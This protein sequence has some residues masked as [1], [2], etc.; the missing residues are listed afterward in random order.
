MHAVC[1]SQHLHMFPY[2][3]VITIVRQVFSALNILVPL[4]FP[5]VRKPGDTLQCN[6]IINILH[7][8]S[9]YHSF[10]EE[11]ALHLLLWIP[12]NNTLK[13]TVS[14][15]LS[16]QSSPRGCTSVFGISTI[17]STIMMLLCTFP[18]RTCH[19]EPET[20][21]LSRGLF[22]VVRKARFGLV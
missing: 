6:G 9:P 22:G 18:C 20:V 12:T 2:L 13:H 17:L 3:S 15:S 21:H 7:S 5:D 8:Q 14:R 19:L 4:I 1:V 16:L 10:L 11:Y